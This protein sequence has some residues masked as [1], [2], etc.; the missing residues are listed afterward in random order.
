MSF[1]NAVKRRAWVVRN[2]VR[3]GTGTPFCFV[4]RTLRP[5]LPNAVANV[6]AKFGCLLPFLDLLHWI[7]ALHFAFL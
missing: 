5:R 3:E 7:V 1:T 2:F 6:R 4:T